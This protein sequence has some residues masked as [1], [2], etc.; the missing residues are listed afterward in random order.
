M[1]LATSMMLVTY[2]KAGESEGIQYPEDA[3]VLVR[4]S[5]EIEW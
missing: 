3:I 4:G 1:H 5:D 2:T